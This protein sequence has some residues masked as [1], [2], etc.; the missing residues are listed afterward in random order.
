MYD[1]LPTVRRIKQDDTHLVRYTGNLYFST[2]YQTKT[3]TTNV[4]LSAA[5]ISYSKACQPRAARALTS[6]R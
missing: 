3:Q 4:K 1:L 5:A 6:R 2:P